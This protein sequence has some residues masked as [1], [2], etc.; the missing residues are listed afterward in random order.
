MRE[1]ASMGQGLE[2]IFSEEMPTSTTSRQFL[3]A[4]LAENSVGLFIV[5]SRVSVEG[6][7]DLVGGTT[8][9]TLNSFPL[10]VLTSSLHTLRRKRI[11]R[12][13][14]RRTGWCSCRSY[15]SDRSR[16]EPR[17]EPEHDGR[18]WRQQQQRLRRYMT[19]L[20]STNAWDSHPVYHRKRRIGSNG[21][22]VCCA[23]E[24]QGSVSPERRIW[25]WP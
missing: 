4:N 12:Q 16:C 19:A 14:E 9:A 20:P 7:I 24:H 8:H 5:G 25:P 3:P 10:Q 17:I 11:R 21:V 22:L 6:K 23:P 15:C 1:L 18:S 2:N 13:Y